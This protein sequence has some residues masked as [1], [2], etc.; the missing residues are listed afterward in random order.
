A[1]MPLYVKNPEG[2]KEGM[3][4]RQCTSEYKIEVVEKIIRQVLLGLKPRQV[5][6]AN[7]VES[8]F[9]IS[10]DEVYRKRTSTKHWQTFR[11]PLTDDVVS[12]KKD[13][14]FERG[15][16]RQDCLD[17]LRAHGYPD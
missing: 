3:I 15:F 17:W 8:W 6:R 2:G 4:N 16:D 12:P 7:A 14:L 9:G 13:Q 5:A 10:A 11:Y 1:S